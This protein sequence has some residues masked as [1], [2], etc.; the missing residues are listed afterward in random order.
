MPDDRFG[1]PELTGRWVGFYRHRSADT[2]AFPITAEIHQDGKRI[3]GEMYDQITDREDLLEQLIEL[4]Q[5]KIDA[6]NQR[7]LDQVIEQFGSGIIMVNSHL[8]ET[9][10]IDGTIAGNVV[11]FTKCYR[12]SHTISW[13]VRGEPI[14]SV[15]REEHK[16]CYAGHLDRE[17][18]C[19]TGEWVIRFRG[20]LG[21]FLPPIARGPFELYGTP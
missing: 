13:T 1:S 4:H 8:P 14:R 20:F 3:T 7:R 18:N 19:I 10:D 12:G 15:T 17:R 11:R 21:Q 5:D 6:W 2:R 16:V 9:S